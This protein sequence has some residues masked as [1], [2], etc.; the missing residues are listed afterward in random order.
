M[1]NLAMMVF[2]FV[3]LAGAVL[4]AQPVVK[5]VDPVQSG[6][7]D[8]AMVS[9]KY[10]PADGKKEARVE[11]TQTRATTRELPMKAVEWEVKNLDRQIAQLQARITELEDR[12]QA[13][14]GAVPK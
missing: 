5:G 1:R 4:N 13:I 7:G 10:V 8:T 3:V 2:A 12:K 6:Q 11:I 14:L 9:V